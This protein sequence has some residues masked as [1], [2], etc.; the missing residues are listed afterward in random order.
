LAEQLRR[1]AGSPVALLVLAAACWGT[2][3]AVSKQA[4]AVVPPMTLLAVQLAASLVFVLLAG[5]RTRLSAEDAPIRRLGLLNPGLSYA[6]GLIGLT[7]ITASAA[8]LLWALEP[9]GILVLAAVLLGERVGGRVIALSALAIGG[10]VVVLY[11]SAVSGETVAI[12]ISAAGVACCAVYTIAARAWLRASDST[13]AVVFGQQLYALAFAV[14]VV[15]VL[16]V[17]GAQV[18]PSSMTPLV[19]ASALGSGLLY[20][21]FA[22]WLYLSALR[23]LPASLASTSVYL[24]PIFGLVAAA[25]LGERLAPVQWLGAVVVVAAMLGIAWAARRSIAPSP[26]PSGGLAAS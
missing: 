9:I 7:G 1:V 23:R 17:A 22:Y 8:V 13:V 12:A 2:G 25:T 24:I 21:G 18:L 15:A 6:L 4:V 5:G 10:L 19:L 11:D 26:E 20:Y 16:G 3:T 14:A